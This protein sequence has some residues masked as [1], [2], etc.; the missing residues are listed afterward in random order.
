[1]KLSSEAFDYIEHNWIEVDDDTIATFVR[2]AL[3]EPRDAYFRDDELYVTHTLAFHTPAWHLTDDDIL[4]QA[5]Y[6]AA[7]DILEPLGAEPATVGHWTYSQFQCIKVPMLDEDGAITAAAVAL[8][9]LANSDENYG[10]LDED[11]YWELQSEVNDRAMNDAIDWFER[12]REV[13]FDDFQKQL[14][15]STYWEQWMGYHEPGHIDDGE[16]LE[17]AEK[18]LAGECQSHQETKLW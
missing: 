7:L 3:E 9:D 6:R 5:N 13:E 16:F 1:M 17:I 2:E 8:W 15:A 18:V 14:I 12:E 11:L 4:G 10:V